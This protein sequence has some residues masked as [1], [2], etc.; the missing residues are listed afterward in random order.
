MKKSRID[1]AQLKA[2]VG[3]KLKRKRE[4]LTPTSSSS[5]KKKVA[6]KEL[7]EEQPAS[8]PL[9]KDNASSSR[10]DPLTPSPS[11]AL[12]GIEKTARVEGTKTSTS[13]ITAQP[14]ILTPRVKEKFIKV[15]DF[16]RLIKSALLDPPL[17]FG[18]DIV[19]QNANYYREQAEVSESHSV[20]IFYTH[21]LPMSYSSDLG[22]VQWFPDSPRPSRRIEGL[23]VADGRDE[24]PSER[25]S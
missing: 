23:Q 15:D 3:V 9:E 11:A 2:G 13:I 21:V 22:I 12:E 10:K 25:G 18:F 14:S 8:P 20:H 17:E 16:C 1:L 7:I 19:S 5:S 4:P 24:L 6:E